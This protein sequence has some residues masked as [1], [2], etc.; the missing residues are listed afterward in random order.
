VVTAKEVMV[1]ATGMVVA[2]VDVV[3]DVEVAG[4]VV[5]VEVVEAV[6]ASAGGGRPTVA[7]KGEERQA[8]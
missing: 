4:M 3:V 8:W 7:E 6:V 5:A 2:L 1:V